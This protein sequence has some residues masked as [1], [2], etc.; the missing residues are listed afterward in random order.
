MINTD[1]LSP[2]AEALAAELQRSD[3]YRVLRRVPKPYPSMPHMGP[4]PDGRCVA[5]VDTETSGLSAEHDVIIEL[6]IM[7]CFVDDGSELIGHFGPFSWL[8]DPG[9]ELDPRISLITGLGAQH[10]MGQ[11]INLSLIHI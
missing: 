2:D 6:A 5:I 10:L 1:H 3:D 7:L 11:K 4:V 8:Q 9:R